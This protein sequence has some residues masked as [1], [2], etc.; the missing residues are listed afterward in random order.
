M[1]KILIKSEIIEKLI[2]KF[3]NLTPEAIKAS[4]DVILNTIAE[5]LGTGRRVE[6][7]QFGNFHVRFRQARIARNPKTGDKI[8]TPERLYPKFKLSPVVLNRIQQHKE[9]NR[10]K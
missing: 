7:R 9:K 4:I 6:I 5:G 1:K 10:L 2:D 8:D 3:P